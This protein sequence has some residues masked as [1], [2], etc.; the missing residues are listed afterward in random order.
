MIIKY[1]L[2]MRA[3][4]LTIINMDIKAEPTSIPVN[5]TRKTT[6][7]IDTVELE[8]V[9]SLRKTVTAKV[10]GVTIRDPTREEIT[11]R[12]MKDQLRK[13]PILVSQLKE[14]K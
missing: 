11:T 12:T 2:N 13:S 7:T 3:K 10:T 4:M 6:P 9:M 1:K 14:E 8:E 5:L